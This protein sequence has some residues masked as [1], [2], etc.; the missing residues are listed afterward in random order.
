MATCRYFDRGGS[1]VHLGKK[2]APGVFFDIDPEK[3]DSAVVCIH[4][5]DP[6]GQTPAVAVAE[7][8]FEHLKPF[9]LPEGDPDPPPSPEEIRL[10]QAKAAE[11][12]VKEQQAAEKAA[13]IAL[14]K[15]EAKAAK[16]AKITAANAAKAEKAR[17]AAEK[18]AAAALAKAERQRTQKPKPRKKSKKK[19]R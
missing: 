14:K 12:A 1:R 3:A 4:V 15:R 9:T 7:V 6:L 8:P 11:Q 10:T 2:V 5:A 19:G 13:V 17:V 18:K 16:E